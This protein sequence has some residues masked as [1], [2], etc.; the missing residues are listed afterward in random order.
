MPIELHAV[1]CHTTQHAMLSLSLCTSIPLTLLIDKTSMRNFNTEITVLTR[2]WQSQG[3]YFFLFSHENLYCLGPSA[4]PQL[5][6]Y[7]CH[8][9]ASAHLCSPLIIAHLC[10]YIIISHYM[11]NK[12]TSWTNTI[13]QLFCTPRH[14]GSAEPAL[15]TA[16]RKLRLARK[17]RGTAQVS[18]CV[19]SWIIAPKVRL[20]ISGSLCI[21]L[22]HAKAQESQGSGRGMWTQGPNNFF[23]SGGMF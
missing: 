17:R 6:A 1:F 11:I 3:C 22:F 19:H 21:Q 10:T 12:D 16:R 8:S 23:F 7:L 15:P 18:M 14:H 20:A 4:R 9:E 5:G 13:Y 2:I